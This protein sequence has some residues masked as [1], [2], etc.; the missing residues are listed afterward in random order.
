[1]PSP[2]LK[3]GCRNSLECQILVWRSGVSWCRCWC[4]RVQTRKTR[5]FSHEVVRWLPVLRY[6]VD[7]IALLVPG[8]NWSATDNNIRWGRTICLLIE[9]SFLDKSVILKGLWWKLISADN[10]RPMWKTHDDN[11]ERSL[12]SQLRIQLFLHSKGLSWGKKSYYFPWGSAVP[13]E[14]P[15]CCW[16]L[17]QPTC[18]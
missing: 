15:E 18:F 12:Q 10:W 13:K 5:S 17:G 7:R 1:M 3:R 2:W 6:C 8:S 16:F 14:R 4:G 9:K 11:V